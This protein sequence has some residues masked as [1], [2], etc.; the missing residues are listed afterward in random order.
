MSQQE[1]KSLQNWIKNSKI[2]F[3]KHKSNVQYAVKNLT[4]PI[5]Y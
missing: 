1:L 4:S 5:N 3:L 2:Q